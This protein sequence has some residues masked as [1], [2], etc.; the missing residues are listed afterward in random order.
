[1]IR[2]N[3][4]KNVLKLSVAVF[5]IL[6][7]IAFMFPSAINAD[8]TNV[9]DDNGPNMA[10]P[11][12][13]YILRLVN[14]SD[15]YAKTLTKQYFGEV[16]G[17]EVVSHMVHRVPIPTTYQNTGITATVIS[18]TSI[19]WAGYEAL[20]SANDI[21]GAAG[22]FVAEH[23]TNGVDLAWVGVGGE[24]STANLAQIGLDMNYNNGEIVPF[25]EM[26]PQQS[27]IQPIY[28]LTAYTGDTLLCMVCN[29]KSR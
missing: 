12:S 15:D 18:H 14:V 1:L 16:I 10:T 7:I 24:P 6:A 25:Y 13:G 11:G 21:K 19:N 2:S 27:S 17:D 22:Q 28:N 4:V 29:L 3:E 9:G 23:S 26:Y 20:R 8:G 5:S